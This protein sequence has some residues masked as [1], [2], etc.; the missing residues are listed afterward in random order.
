MLDAVPDWVDW[1]SP[2]QCLG[3]AAC[4]LAVLAFLQRNDRRL[5]QWMLIKSVVYA[6]H[7]A[8]LG[9]WPAVVSMI[10]AMLRL[11]LSLRTRAWSVALILMA[12]TLG[13]AFVLVRE[14]V[15]AL[16]LLASLLAT[17]ALFRCEGVRMRFVLLA[18]TA[19]WLVHNVMVGSVGGVALEILIGVASVLTIFR[20]RAGAA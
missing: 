19:L 15:D 14:W 16:P 18:S 9:A 5:K 10:L 6:L 17:Y 2:A 13:L 4:G 12:A 1:A 7:F 11:G 20:L 8:L 3:Y